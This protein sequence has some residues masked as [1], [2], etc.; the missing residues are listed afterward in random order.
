MEG[1]LTPSLRRDPAGAQ[2]RDD[3]LPRHRPPARR[4]FPLFARLEFESMLADVEACRELGVAG[5]VVGCL[6][7]DGRIDEE[8][9]RRLVEAARPMSVTCHR[10]FD[11]TRDIRRGARGADPLRGRSRADQR[12]ARHGGRGRRQSA[13]HGRAG[14]RPDHHHGLRRARCLQHRASAPPRR[15]DELHFAALKTE[16]SAM[17]FPQPSGRHGRHRARPRIREHAHRHGCG[18]QDHRSGPRRAD[19]LHR[20]RG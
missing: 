18:A 7:A 10:A 8:R 15:A 5:V 20:K 14:R 13:P 6:T 12:P 17:T 16:P 3:P 11:M 9:M 19:E 1:G 4:R 2:G